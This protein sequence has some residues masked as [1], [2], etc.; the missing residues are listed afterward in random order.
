LPSVFDLVEIIERYLCTRHE[1]NEMIAILIL[2]IGLAVT[3]I[4]GILGILIAGILSDART[5]PPSSGRP[6]GHPA[7]ARLRPSYATS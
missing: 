2:N 1:E 4:A 7:S 5:R 3:V 6:G